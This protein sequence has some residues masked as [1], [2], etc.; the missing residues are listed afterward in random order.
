MGSLKP[1][2]GNGVVCG[3]RERSKVKSMGIGDVKDA[4]FYYPTVTEMSDE[5]VGYYI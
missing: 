3:A 2:V 5:A 1:Q 4:V